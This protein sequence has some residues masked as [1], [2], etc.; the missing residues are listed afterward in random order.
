[1]TLTVRRIGRV[2]LT[3]SDVDL[4]WTV[5]ALKERLLEREVEEST[6]PV[7]LGAISLVLLGAVLDDDAV[8]GTLN[9]DEDTALTLIRRQAEDGAGALAE[10][11]PETLEEGCAALVQ[12][13]GAVDRVAADEAPHVGAAVEVGGEGDAEAVGDSARAAPASSEGAF[14]ESAAADAAPPAGAESVLGASAAAIAT[15]AAALAPAA[16]NHAQSSPELATSRRAKAKAPQ[17]AATTIGAGCDAERRS[18]RRAMLMNS[19]PKGP[20]RGASIG[21]PRGRTLNRLESRDD[22]LRLGV[23]AEFVAESEVGAAG[24]AQAAGERSDAL[25]YTAWVGELSIVMSG[26][27]TKPDYKRSAQH[28]PRSGRV[29]HVARR[30]KTRWW[31]LQSDNKLVYYK[32]QRDGLEARSAGEAELESAR[33]EYA[34]YVLGSI[35][36]DTVSLVERSRVADAPE[37]ALD[38]L[39]PAAGPGGGTMAYTIGA[40][41]ERDMGA[42]AQVSV[43]LCTVTLYANLAHSLTRSP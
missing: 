32:R 19:V 6:A 35:D 38:L 2:E 1:M 24:S 8:L 30:Y 16:T 39:V 21:A 43:L 18:E 15:R 36:L 31:E 22:A 26:F 34:Q 11:L 41:S 5:Q 29:K 12:G 13:A 25:V 10:T 20:K 4:R 42:W 23:G 3:V 17:R 37:W 40:A 14:V 33:T 9:L 27:L 7:A 28:A